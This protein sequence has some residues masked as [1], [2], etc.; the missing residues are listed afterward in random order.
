[1]D[2]NNASL[3]RRSWCALAVLARCGSVWRSHAPQPSRWNRLGVGT[4]SVGSAVVG[5]PAN[6]NDTATKTRVGWT[7]GVGSEFAIARN[8]TVRTETNYFDMG[9]ER[10]T[11]PVFNSV[12]DARETGFISTVGVN[13]RF[14]PELVVA[15][16]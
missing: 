2:R 10:D 3:C 1:M 13:Y 15:K 12:I 16:Y 4:G 8:W 14:A 6:C 5:L 7:V 9:T 11:L